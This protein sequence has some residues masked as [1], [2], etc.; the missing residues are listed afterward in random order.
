MNSLFP[1]KWSTSSRTNDSKGFSGAQPVPRDVSLESRTRRSRRSSTERGLNQRVRRHPTGAVPHL[2]GSTEEREL[3]EVV[4]Q[5]G[6][7]V[8]NGVAAVGAGQP[9]GEMVGQGVRMAE[10]L[11]FHDGRRVRL[12]HAG[13]DDDVAVVDDR[14]RTR[15]H[16]LPFRGG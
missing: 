5:Y 3:V 16:E 1:E 8:L 2:A 4:V 11:A 7:E 14:A 9:L 12:S 15:H 13:V 10:A 6:A